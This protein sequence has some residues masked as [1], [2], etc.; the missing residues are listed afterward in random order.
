MRTFKGGPLTFG[1]Y[2]L[3]VVSWGI[4]CGDKNHPGVYAKVSDLVDQNFQ[5]LNA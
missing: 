3:G 2:V 1:Q 4:D 5:F